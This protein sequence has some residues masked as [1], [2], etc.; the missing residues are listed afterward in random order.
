MEQV[1][2]NASKY[3]MALIPKAWLQVADMFGNVTDAKTV[4]ASI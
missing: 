3:G 1:A 2:W 4:F